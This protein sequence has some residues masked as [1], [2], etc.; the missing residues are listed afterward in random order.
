MWSVKYLLALNAQCLPKQLKLF[1]DYRNRTEFRILLGMF[2]I[3]KAKV[4]KAF[5]LWKL[6]CLHIIPSHTIESLRN[7]AV[8]ERNGPYWILNRQKKKLHSFFHS[9]C[10]SNSLTPKIVMATSLNSFNKGLDKCIQVYQELLVKVPHN[11]LQVEWYDA[12][13]Y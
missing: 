9:I 2:F 5:I 6:S 12:S 3:V 13:E 11:Y 1:P 7:A 4:V 8:P 10:Q